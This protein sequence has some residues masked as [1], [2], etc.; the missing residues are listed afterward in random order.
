M[1]HLLLI[2]L[3]GAFI[4]LPAQAQANEN[5][6]LKLI[7]ELPVLKKVC[8]EYECYKLN[9][10]EHYALVTTFASKYF[11]FNTK[12]KQL[13]FTGNTNLADPVINSK[14]YSINTNNDAIP[15]ILLLVEVPT[16]KGTGVYT[17]SVYL[18]TVTDDRV[19]LVLERPNSEYSTGWGQYE[20]AMV[21]FRTPLPEV[22]IKNDVLT[23]TFHPKIILNDT[24]PEGEPEESGTI[25]QLPVEYF[26]WLPERETFVQF[27]GR[28][29]IA[30][31]FMSD[32][33]ADFATIKGNWFKKPFVIKHGKI[34][35]ESN[36]QP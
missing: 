28:S 26:K 30:K 18:Y 1:K 24:V 23:L 29:V 19:D 33:Y 4:L 9:K 3:V 2:I 14:A 6:D 16:S 21:T 8:N 27:E 15:R 17:T 11:V 20:E 36:N 12:T 13:I 34:L 7:N 25:K 32:M 35:K 22:E 10:F 5:L 31:D